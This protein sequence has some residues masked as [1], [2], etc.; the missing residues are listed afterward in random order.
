MKISI[1]FFLPSHTFSGGPS[2]VVVFNSVI[3]KACSVSSTLI[4][5]NVILEKQIK[6]MMIT[7]TIIV[8]DIPMVP[9]NT[10]F[11]LLQLDV[12]SA[13]ALF[14]RTV[15]VGYSFYQSVCVDS[16]KA[17]IGM[18][19]SDKLFDTFGCVFQ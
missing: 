2:G 14:I 17:A 7:V 3:D 6:R 19:T 11:E 4:L 12:I 13:T 9:F 5:V 1:S 18:F 15:F 10:W 8:V 16:F